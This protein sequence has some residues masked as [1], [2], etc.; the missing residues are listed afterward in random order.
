MPYCDPRHSVEVAT[1]E[2]LRS[3]L[4]KA[5]A[6]GVLALRVVET[7]E[8]QLYQAELGHQLAAQR[9]FLDSAKRLQ[10]QLDKL[11]AGRCINK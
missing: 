9:D 3:A 4:D 11:L 7:P 6:L 2:E 1:S 5:H 8:M 10:N